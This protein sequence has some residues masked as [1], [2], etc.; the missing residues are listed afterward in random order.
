[1]F[2]VAV[3]IALCVPECLN[4][5]IQMIQFWNG[6]WK[7]SI[8]HQPH[9]PSAASR[10]HLNK[11]LINIFQSA[12]LVDQTNE[13]IQLIRQSPAG[14]GT[15]SSLLCQ[16]HAPLSYRSCLMAHAATC[17]IN[18]SM[19]TT[20]QETLSHRDVRNSILA[21]YSYSSCCVYMLCTV[22]IF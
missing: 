17:H 10:W 22:L 3:M 16:F 5:P 4:K 21:Y 6:S 12:K 18:A 11:Q 1:M 14:G 19:H 13:W 15:T 7:G 8:S 2:I 9:F 20:S